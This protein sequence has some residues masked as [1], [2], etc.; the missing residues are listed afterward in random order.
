MSSSTRSPMFSLDDGGSVVKAILSILFMAIIISMIHRVYYPATSDLSKAEVNVGFGDS[1]D[2]ITASATIRVEA[3]VSDDVDWSIPDINLP[4]SSIPDINLPTSG[5]TDINLPTFKIL[6]LYL[7][8]C[9]KNW[10]PDC[11]WLEHMVEVIC[12][13]REEAWNM[14]VNVLLMIRDFLK[15]LLI[16]V[17]DFLALLLSKINMPIKHV[18]CNT[19]SSP[20]EGCSIKLLRDVLDVIDEQ[21]KIFLSWIPSNF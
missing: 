21:D 14:M 2:S 11:S 17:C 12:N 1:G 4:T 18:D 16:I 20:W 7:P 9:C 10:N 3:P 8:K 5:I 6:P 15:G 13:F 19:S